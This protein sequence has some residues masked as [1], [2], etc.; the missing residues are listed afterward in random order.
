MDFIEKQF[1]QGK[2][3]GPESS[4][5]EHTFI[6]TMFGFHRLAITPF[7]KENET[8]SF[9]FS[10]RLPTERNSVE[11]KRSNFLSVLCNGVNNESNQPLTIDHISLICNG[12][13]YNYKELYDMMNIE[14][15]ELESVS[16]CEVI[17]HLY[18]RY[19]IE[20]TLTMLDGVFAFV[21]CDSRNSMLD[22][23]ELKNKI[24]VARDPY[25]VRPLYSLQISTSEQSCSFT[26]RTFITNEKNDLEDES[27]FEIFNYVKKMEGL[28]KNMVFY[29]FASELKS[30]YQFPEY[31]Q[32]IKNTNLNQSKIEQFTPGT[33]SEFELSNKILSQWKP[34]KT[35][36]PYYITSF[37]SF[38]YLQDLPRDSI[39]HYCIH[40]QKKLVDAVYKRCIMTERPRACLLTGELDSSLIT[41]LV[42]EYQKKK[43]NSSALET[44][45]IGLDNSV[46]ILYARKVADYLKTNHTEIIVTEQEM[47]DAIP[48]VIQTIESYDTTT[49][50]ESIGN[51]LLGKY[52]SKNSEAK[53]IFN[54]DGSDEI[55]GGYLYMNQCPDAIEF[56]R[57]TRRLLK[58]IHLFDV[59]RSDKSISSHG[60]EPI[61]PFLDPNFVN[62]YLSIPMEYRFHTLQNKCEKYLL[63]ES[64]SK[65]YFLNSEENPLLP[66][67]ILW[68]RKEAFSD[69]ITSE[70]R[71]LFQIIQEKIAKQLNFESNIETE[72]Y[73]YK[74]LFD[75]FYPNQET[76]LPYFCMPKY[77][78]TKDPSVHRL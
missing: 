1:H 3:R 39:V 32:N 19:G 51:Y 16:N 58:N 60:L 57:E 26:N 13:I 14:E 15:A 24:F 59:L 30:L 56:D 52:I 35:N 55:C 70:G 34:I 21:L 17:I 40:I 22:N 12:E 72:K 7:G 25:G 64:F 62:Y 33:Y 2:N 67:E 18:K 75:E 63:R 69:C 78:N 38:I 50:R 6:K 42:N 9:S 53:V 49:V 8:N 47:F 66:D 27:S 23:S 11:A 68:R 45:S 46:D 4:K 31:Y 36:V 73:Y 29:G 5:L 65:N 48:E 10:D 44:Y 71:S 74:K 54:G 77:T 28:N 43:M 37:P 61:T 76:I 41:A 20:Q